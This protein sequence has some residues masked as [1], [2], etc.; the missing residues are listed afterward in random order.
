M[1]VDLYLVDGYGIDLDDVYF[2]DD[3]DLLTFLKEYDNNHQTDFL[4]GY[5]EIDEDSELVGFDEIDNY[6]EHQL[7]QKENWCLNYSI[8]SGY[9]SSKRYL[10]IPRVL[11]LKGESE[12]HLKTKEEIVDLIF[13]VLEPLIEDS[14]EELNRWVDNVFDW[15][16]R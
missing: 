1:S 9:H 4:N 10:Y 12:R 15:E 8:F 14:K 3:Y 13:N 7:D 16:T 11:P 2:K 5:T 6:I